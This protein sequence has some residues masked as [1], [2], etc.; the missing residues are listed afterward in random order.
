MPTEEGV[1]DLGDE[2]EGSD[3]ESELESSEVEMYSQAVLEEKPAL[4]P[5]SYNDRVNAAEA[6]VDFI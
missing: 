1:A 5:A 6:N 3:G 4:I 2:S